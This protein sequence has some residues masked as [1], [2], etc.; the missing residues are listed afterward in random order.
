VGFKPRKRKEIWSLKATFKYIFK[1][2]QILK[3]CLSH[4]FQ[5]VKTIQKSQKYKYNIFTKYYFN[6]L[7][8]TSENIYF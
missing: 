2:I 1:T 6:E 3:I 8:Q 7:T 4:K 5:I